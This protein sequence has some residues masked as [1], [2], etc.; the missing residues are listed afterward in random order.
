MDDT[1]TVDDWRKEL[2]RAKAD[3][4][5]SY[6]PIKDMAEAMGLTSGGLLKY[7]KKRGIETFMVEK[8]HRS[9]CTRI[10]A[11]TPFNAKRIVKMREQDRC[12]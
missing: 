5:V 3:A 11:V 4:I 8:A 2:D 6:V 1:I 7:V 12:L 10:N 9:G